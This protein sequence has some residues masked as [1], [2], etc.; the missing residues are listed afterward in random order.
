MKTL[1]EMLNGCFAAAFEKAGYDAKYGKCNVS[2][3]P[4][5]CEFQC[6][7]AMASA[8]AYK[9]PPI[10]IANEVVAALEN[11]GTFDKVEAVMP[12]FIN[13]TL[14]NK[15]LDK[16]LLEMNTADNLGYEPKNA[17]KTLIVDY[18][19]ANVAKPLHVGHL[20]PAIIGESVKRMLAFDGYKAIGDVH[21]GDWGLPMGLIITECSKRYPDLVYFDENYEGEYPSE[22]PFAIS[23]LEEIYPYAC[24]YSKEHPEYKEEARIATAQLQA[25]RRGYRALWKHILNVSKADLKKNYDNLNVHFELWNGESD[26]DSLI[27]PMVEKMKADGVAK[28]SEGAVVVDVKEETDNKEMPPCILVKSDGAAI[29]ASTDLATLVEREQDYKPDFIVY[30]VDKRQSLHF[31]QVFRTA[32]K[33]GIIRPETRLHHIGNG[34]M[35]GPDGTPFK[36]RDGGVMRL[37]YLIRDIAAKVSE[38]MADRELSAEE[39]ENISKIVGLAALKYGDLSN[40][41]TKDYIFDVDKFTAFEG[42]TGPYI[43]YTMVRIKSILDKYAS[44]SGSTIADIRAAAEKADFAADYSSAD[45]VDSEKKLKLAIAAFA[46]NISN[47]ADELAPHKICSYIFDLSNLFNSFYHENKIIA[48]EDKAKQK[49][50]ISLICLTLKCLE[51]C[52]DMLAI[53]AP[54]RM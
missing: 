7:G 37:E 52:T 15:M 20:R 44:V 32:R 8:K 5:L 30:V 51:T 1:M 27:A 34:T 28:L 38:K 4:D 24:A 53:S 39:R 25:G 9:K 17:G 48:E 43:L 19:G 22:A 2:N 46:D 41:A 33:A 11:D 31:E 36:T 47:A 26:V 49:H 42:N 50:W 14:S 54:E 13:I 18:G 10:A 40:A 12:G 35:N 6:N 45:A 16:Y 21:L 23:D 29:Y 3:R